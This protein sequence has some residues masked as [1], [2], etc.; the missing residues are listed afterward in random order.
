MVT[1]SFSPATAIF[2]VEGLDKLWSLRGRLE[3]PL[4]HIAGVRADPSVAHGWWHG[5]RLGGTN[6]PGVLTAGT[7]Y[8][9]GGFVFWDVHDPEGTIVVDL[10][11]EHYRALVIEVAHPRQ[12]AADIMARLPRNT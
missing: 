10:E 8:H 9:E 5:L 7:F 3:I 11:H 1:V 12:V 2:E 4:A 6:L